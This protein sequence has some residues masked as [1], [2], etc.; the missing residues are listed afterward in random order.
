MFGLVWTDRV[1][2]RCVVSGR[3][4]VSSFALKVCWLAN[5]RFHIVAELVCLEL[6]EK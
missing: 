3:F 5:V 6:S 2:K 4:W 1:C